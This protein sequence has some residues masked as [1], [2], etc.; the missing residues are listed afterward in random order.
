MVFMHM[1]RLAQQERARIMRRCFHFDYILRLTFC[2]M[3]PSTPKNAYFKRHLGLL[4]GQDIGVTSVENS[5]GRAAEELT[6]GSAKLNL[7]GS[8]SKQSVPSKV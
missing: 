2:P 5:E 1:A 3:T 4:V 8:R 6:A 7:C